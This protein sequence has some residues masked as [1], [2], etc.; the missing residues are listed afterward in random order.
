MLIN[1]ISIDAAD[2][3]ETTPLSC[4]SVFLLAL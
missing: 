2:T 1:E 3:R 4:K